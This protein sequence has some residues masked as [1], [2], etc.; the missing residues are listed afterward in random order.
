[1]HRPA[2]AFPPGDPAGWIVLFSSWFYSGYAP[3]ASGTFGTLAAIPLVLLLALLGPTAYALI[4]V[5]L[6]PVACYLAE[7]AEKIHGEKD[8]GEIVIDEVA[9]FLVACIGFQ[10]YPLWKV[11]L[12]SF[13]LFRLFDVLKLFPGNYFDKV[14]GGGAGVVLDDI[15]AG[16][17][18]AA[19]M[20]LILGMGWL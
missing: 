3:V 11:L 7:E 8:P 10:F 9:G 6:I 18:A 2:P 14:F 16:V 5:F 12:V 13:V 1:M 19:G 4:A 17:Y 20:H 15:V